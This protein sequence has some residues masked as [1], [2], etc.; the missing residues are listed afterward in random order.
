MLNPRFPGKSK[1]K[2]HEA[3]WG[4][5]RQKLL[6]PLLQYSWL[7]VN[8]FVGELTSWLRGSRVAAST[9]SGRKA[10]YTSPPSFNIVGV[11]VVVIHPVLVVV[12]GLLF[13]V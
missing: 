5:E 6:L 7:P 10:L 8:G 11:V 2:E 1:E 3:T 9:F 12:A 13:S 4:K